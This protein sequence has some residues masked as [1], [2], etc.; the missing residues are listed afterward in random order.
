LIVPAREGTLRVLRA[1]RDAGVKRV[2]LTSSFAAIGYGAPKDRT[3]LF[4][5]KDWTNLN[6]PTVQPYQKSKTIAERAAWDFLAREGG[7]LELAVVNPVLVL[8]PVLG[9]DTSPSILLIS[10]STTKPVL[11]LVPPMSMT[12][13]VLIG[14]PALR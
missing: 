10:P 5:E 11:M 14:I 6:D 12:S 8:G 9:A 4:T 7:E 13:M 3:A 2:V 1:S